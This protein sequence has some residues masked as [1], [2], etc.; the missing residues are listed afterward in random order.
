[1]YTR[2][3][4][5]MAL[6]SF[7]RSTIY[8]LLLFTLKEIN[9]F[10]ENV[11]STVHFMFNGNLHKPTLLLSPLMESAVNGAMKTY[12]SAMVGATRSRSSYACPYIPQMQVWFVL[13]IT[14]S[15]SLRLS[16][17]PPHMRNANSAS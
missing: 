7:L 8:T 5:E 14:I 13:Y 16:E 1:M 15:L 17:S 9:I 3:L 6:D 2:L 12:N 4:E 10:A 11:Y